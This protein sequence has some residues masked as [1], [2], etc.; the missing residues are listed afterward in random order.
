MRAFQTCTR[1]PFGAIPIRRTLA[2]NHCP[3]N[4]A[5]NI[6]RDRNLSLTLH[7]LRGYHGGQWALQSRNGLQKPRDGYGAVA[8]CNSSIREYHSYGLKEVAEDEEDDDDDDDEEYDEDDDDDDDEDD[9]DDEEEDDEDD[10]DEDDKDDE[11]GGGGG[12]KQRIIDGATRLSMRNVV[13]PSQILP[14]HGYRRG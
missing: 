6:V 10:D 2:G 3:L 7:C 5:I 11:G 14:V 4:R 12:L 13:P 1:S 8:G 9:E